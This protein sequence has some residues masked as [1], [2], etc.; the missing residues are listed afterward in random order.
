[1]SL[2]HH[3]F[4]HHRS[5]S[6]RCSVIKPSRFTYG[7]RLLIVGLCVL[8]MIAVQFGA[9]VPV[10]R[11]ESTAIQRGMSVEYAISVGPPYGVPVGP[12]NLAAEAPGVIWFT[13]PQTGSPDI[14]GGIGVL[15]RTVFSDTPVISYRVEFLGLPHGSEPYDLVVGDGAVWFTLRGTGQIGR[16]D[17]ATKAITLYDIPTANS[18]PT[19]ID[20]APDG[21]VWFAESIG[22]IGQFDPT[23]ETFT[24]HPFPPGRFSAPRVEQLRVQNVRNIWFTLPDAKTLGNY[25]SVT[26]EFFA[27]PTGERTPTGLTLD[28]AGRPWVTAAGTGKV[29]R[30]A[31]GTVTQWGW[32]NAPTPDSALAGIATFDTPEGREVWF[33]ESNTEAGSN[34]G[35]VGRLLTTGYRLDFQ[36]ALPLSMNQASR[37]WGVVVDDDQRVWIADTERRVIYE[38]GVPLKVYFPQIGKP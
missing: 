7:T 38:T 1:M 19:G 22:Q 31:P 24:E 36:E 4:L 25:N 12:L 30:Y 35:S 5:R 2:Q 6:P 32:F 13:A 29:G 26:G 34:T 10:A 20:I 28:S 3:L 8:A 33:A 14:A 11:A 15:T 37:P 27:V 18:Q 23:S 9:A 17:T 21:Q 16:V